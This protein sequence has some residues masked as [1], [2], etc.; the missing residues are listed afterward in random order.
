MGTFLD[1]PLFVLRRLAPVRAAV[2][3]LDRPVFRRLPLLPFPLCVRA[4]PNLGLLLAGRVAERRELDGFVRFAR[5]TGASVFWD[6]GANVGLY[7]FA[8]VAARPGGAVLAVEPDARNLECLRRTV[9]RAGLSGVEL[10]AAA[11]SSEAGRATFLLDEVGGVTGTIEERGRESFVRRHYG[12]RPR[13][14]EVGTATLDSLLDGRAAPQIVKIDVEG[15]EARTLAGAARLLGEIRPAVLIELSDGR[16][17][18]EA[19]LRAHRYA[20][21]DAVE[22][23]PATERSWNVWALPEER[24]PA[25]L[26]AFA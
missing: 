5:A 9:A 7:A 3:A 23:G 10:V 17:A 14:I 21:F 26:A 20:L 22:L 25:L 18:A 15:A 12:V 11:A 19:T 24:A 6:V 8:F 13:G 4:G 2:R 16:A 1:S